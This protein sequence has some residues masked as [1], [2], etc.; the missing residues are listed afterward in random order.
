MS[1]SRDTDH[2]D[3]DAARQAGRDAYKGVQDLK[4]DAKQAARQLHD[5]GNQFRQGWD[6]AKHD[7]ENK[8]RPHR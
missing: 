1:C 3:G 8:P 5:A 4:H 7:N 6:E 2:R